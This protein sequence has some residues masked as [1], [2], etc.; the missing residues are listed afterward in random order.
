MLGIGLMLLAYFCFS[1]IDTSA[2]WLAAAGIPAMQ[3]AFMRYFG[4]FAISFGL[5]RQRGH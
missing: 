4:H 2:K 1:N 3:L 5:H